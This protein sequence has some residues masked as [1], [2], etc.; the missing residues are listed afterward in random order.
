MQRGLPTKRRIPNVAKTLLVS[1]AKGGVG[2]ST[3]AANIAVAAA[4]G[5]HVPSI[6]GSSDTMDTT[7]KVDTNHPLNRPL[8]VGLLDLDLFG[9]SIPKLLKLEGHQPRVDSR[10]RLL[11][12][13]NYGVKSMSMG[14]LIG[15]SGE[16][17]GAPVAWRGLMVMKAVQQ[18]LWEVEWGGIQGEGV[19]LLVVDMPPG[20]GDV[21]LTVGQQVVVDGGSTHTHTL[22]LSPTVSLV[23]ISWTNHKKKPILTLLPLFKQKQAQ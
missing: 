16:G 20:T 1:S 4:L 18:L 6:Q 23:F 5:L 12:L 17:E 8:K 9:P 10:D 14:Y 21:Q 13:V 7:G 19:D 11:P 2:K 3:V 15:G 22:L